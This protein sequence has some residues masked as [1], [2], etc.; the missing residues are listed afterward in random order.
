MVPVMEDKILAQRWAESTY[1][2]DRS[3]S[4]NYT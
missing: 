2:L 3:S 4:K 1:N